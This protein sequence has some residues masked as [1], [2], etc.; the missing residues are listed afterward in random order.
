MNKPVL[1]NNQPT[2]WMTRH[3]VVAAVLLH[4][5]WKLRWYHAV[6]LWLM[7]LAYGWGA[8][9]Y[10]M[11]YVVGMPEPGTA[12]RY[13]GTIR[14][15]G[16]LER[17]KNGWKPPKYFIQTSNGDVEFH[18]GYLPVRNQCLLSAV[19]GTQPIEGGIYEIGFDPYWGLD[20]IK[21][22]PPLEKM[23]QNRTPSLIVQAR[24]SDLRWHKSDAVWIVALLSGYFSL[25]WHAYRS[26]NPNR[27]VP[28]SEPLAPLKPADFQQSFPKPKHP[29]SFFD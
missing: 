29:T 9:P 24:L 28:T 19:L 4:G 21:Y 17:T 16:K 3:R 8:S 6:L 1:P 5:L 20:Y 27:L 10:L 18:C 14:V 26:S 25:I 23:N 11:V 2:G 13:T 15:E 22:P 7:I 12:P